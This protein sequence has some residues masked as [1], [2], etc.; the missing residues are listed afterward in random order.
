M[1]RFEVIMSKF[2]G[3]GL[4]SVYRVSLQF[5]DQT[6]RPIIEQTVEDRRQS[7][8]FIERYDFWPFTIFYSYLSKNAVLGTKRAPEKVHPEMECPKIGKIEI[9]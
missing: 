5:I 8:F 9:S 3:A 6:L 4:H 1:H 7:F 2:E